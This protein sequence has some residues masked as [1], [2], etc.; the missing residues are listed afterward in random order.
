[1]VLRQMCRVHLTPSSLGNAATP[2]AARES[3]ERVSET[4]E[5]P[6]GI[7]KENSLILSIGRHYRYCR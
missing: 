4:T 3:S 6:R 1:M 5:E 7:F 2:L